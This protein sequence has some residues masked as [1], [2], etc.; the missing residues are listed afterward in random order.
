MVCGKNGVSVDSFLPFL[1]QLYFFKIQTEEELL[2]LSELCNVSHYPMGRVIF[3]EKAGA[4]RF[5][6]VM[7]G[8]V[9]VWKDYYS[10]APDLLGE[11]GEGH[12]FGEM[13]LIDDLP[14]SATVIAAEDT[15]L[16]YVLREDFLLLSEQNV[17]FTKAII[18]SLSAM[19]R[20]SNESFV[21]D[22][23]KRNLELE[24]ANKEL[25]EAQ[26][27]LLRRERLSN[28][29]KFSSL[30]LH[31]IRNPISI[32]KGYV[33]LIHM[34]SGDSGKVRKYC[35]VLLNETQRLHSLTNEMLDYSRGDIRVDLSVVQLD[36]IFSWL[37]E[38][39]ARVFQEQQKT[40]IVENNVKRPVLLDVARMQR[41]FLNL[42]ENARKAMDA[43]GTLRVCA[44]VD[45]G[46]VAI[47]FI[48]S[49]VGMDQDTM[50]AM[51][52][53]FFSKSTMGGTGLGMVIVKSVVQAHGGTITV[54][55]AVDS[56]TTIRISIPL[57]A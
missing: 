4:E 17:N 52:E 13:G 54:D 48:D 6:I 5:F 40:L 44:G 25:K 27:Q 11:H 1:R 32:I 41:V 33:E 26:Q 31:D 43:G 14:R 2:I 36:D 47:D 12:L 8:G 49:G 57:L 20:T 15:K 38:N 28:L 35:G 16:L 53:P 18:R 7:T 50:Q 42:A 37:Q 56:G 39:I 10:S 45:D 34:N 51:F 23:R 3:T 46:K 21:S 19:I 22:L 29:G 30:I 55:S 9:E 24:N